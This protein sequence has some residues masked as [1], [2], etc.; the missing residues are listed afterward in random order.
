MA[1]DTPKLIARLRQDAA[2]KRAAGK[3]AMAHKTQSVADS[4]ERFLGPDTDVPLSDIDADLLNRYSSYLQKEGARENTVSN[5]LRVMHSTVR[6]AAK[7]GLT[8]D[9]TVFAPFFKG[10]AKAVRHLLTVDDL[11]HILAADLDDKGVLLRTRA[12]FLLCFCAG[13]LSIDELIE[14]TS[15]DRLQRL[16]QIKECRV[17][18]SKFPEENWL[19][20]LG[21]TPRET[22]QHNLNGLA[23]TIGLRKPLTD[24]S[25][26]EAWA[27]IGKQLAL[28]SSII[29][30]IVGREIDN[31]HYIDRRETHSEGAKLSALRNVA[32]RIGMDKTHWYVMRCYADEPEQVAAAIQSLPGLKTL[33]LKTFIP[34][35]TSGTARPGQ[36]DTLLMKHMLFINCLLPDALA[37]RKKMAPGIY[38]YDYATEGVKMP[39]IIPDEE[40]RLFMYM[41][42][43][44]SDTLQYYFPDEATHQPVF[45]KQDEVEII[46]GPY[47]GSTARI[48][49]GS[50]DSLKV[51]VEIQ[52]LNVVV[53]AE[54][55]YKFIVPVVGKKK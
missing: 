9:P 6:S 5:Y 41:S 29:A 34:P 39:T 45:R 24:D 54:V 15:G 55:P 10:N 17:L 13:G 14:G 25:A 23:L 11:K 12:L 3:A 52:G 21:K 53:Y 7:S 43:V 30:D 50:K 2:T 26:A 47:A 22:Y 19:S 51:F 18:R 35:V 28:S 4:L 38:I 42:E 27:E 48:Y 36:K 40:M 1:E 33:E 49:K 37:I 20:F 44:A 31:L 8:A 16:Q 46:E 32:D